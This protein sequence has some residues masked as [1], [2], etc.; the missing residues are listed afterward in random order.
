MLDVALMVGRIL[1]LVLLTALVWQI[2]RVT[3]ADL[4]L[5]ARAAE[6]PA[7]VHEPQLVVIAGA[8]LTPGTA[9]PVRGELTLGRFGDNV[10]V[11]QDGYC[12][13]RHA[14][15]WRERGRCY[16][17]DL[18][19]TNGTLVNGHRLKDQPVALSPGAEVRI[20]ETAFRF[21]G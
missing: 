21:E 9:F 4:R 15:V 17:Q 16:I 3:Q 18:G 7:A 8:G 12:S 5:A 2:Y 19:S 13:G 20:G 11:I 1:F 10:I 6:A 14:R